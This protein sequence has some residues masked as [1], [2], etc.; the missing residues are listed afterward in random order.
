MLLIPMYYSVLY[1][2]VFRIVS[3]STT[4]NFSSYFYII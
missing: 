4:I 2:A 3:F 1:Y